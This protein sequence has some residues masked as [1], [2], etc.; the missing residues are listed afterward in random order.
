MD[1]KAP[2]N[3]GFKE[4]SLAELA[5]VLS[6]TIKHDKE[7]K[8][9]TLLGML[10]AYSGDSQI[11]ISFNA[12][13]SSGKTYV[14]SEVA[15]LFPPEDKIELS[16]ASPT[17][18]FYGEGEHDEELNA[19]IVNL[20]RKILIFYEQPDPK[21]Q[22]RLRSVLSHDQRELKFRMTN[23]GKRG[24]NRAQEI[25]IRGFPAT[26]FC[27]AGLRLDEQE[28]TRAILLSPEVTAQKINEGVHL[29]A[30]RG[31]DSAKFINEVET[32]ELRSDLKRRIIAIREQYVGDI[33]IPNP[34]IVEARFKAMLGTVKPRHMRDMAHLMRL[35]K[36]VALLNVWHRRVD[37]VVTVQQ[38]DIDQAF[39]LWSY[40]VESLELGIAPALMN[41]YKDF[42][43]GAYFEKKAEDV[44]G[45]ENPLGVS[46]HEL[47][48]Y[49]YSIT[50][51]PLNDEYLRK[52]ILPQ[53]EN[54]GLI[55]QAKPQAGDRR[56]VHIYPQVLFD[57][58][59]NIGEDGVPPAEEGSK[60]HKH[61][62]LD[63]IDAD[64]LF[65]H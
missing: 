49:H 24:E 51:K 65:D 61:E 45:I 62:Q 30:I 3:E 60:D 17:S 35:I 26:V 28:A 37:G 38:T 11:N 42:I 2:T 43:L 4:L 59:N 5:D 1:N 36:S 15:E 53:L 55:H 52:Q 18:F 23:K 34:E 14:A 48:K 22:A 21:L 57:Q 54:C 33:I 12:P 16:G 56:S 25:I 44:L 6:L 58:E 29:Q 31:A 27:S 50:D 32:N 39:E 19:K 41:F 40:F 9:V 64:G 7:N 47:S 20:D 8:I 63:E 13:S 46:R 10:S